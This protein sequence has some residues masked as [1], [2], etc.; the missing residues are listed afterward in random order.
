MGL[1]YIKSQLDLNI[2][3]IILMKKVILVTTLICKKY[4]NH[5]LEEVEKTNNL[6]EY[7]V[8]LHIKHT[9]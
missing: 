1:T 4:G 3:L 6:M 5:T 7:T 9:Y 2:T 8:L